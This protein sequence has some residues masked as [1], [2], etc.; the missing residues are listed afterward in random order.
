MIPLQS[1][2]V[3]VRCPRC[4]SPLS[5]LNKVIHL[6][7]E[8]NCFFYCNQCQDIVNAKQCS[9][10][11]NGPVVIHHAV[12]ASCWKEV[13]KRDNEI[14]VKNRSCEG[15]VDNIALGHPDTNVREWIVLPRELAALMVYGINWKPTPIS[16][17]L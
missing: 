14:C 10:G 16:R 8:P 15:N 7:K 3:G 12:C 13:G 9:H 11:F 1:P 17:I 6:M 2:P 4:G 5:S